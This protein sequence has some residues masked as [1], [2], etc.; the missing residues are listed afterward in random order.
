LNFDARA[1]GESIWL[2]AEIGKKRIFEITGLA[3]HSMYPLAK[4]LW[5]RRHEPDTFANT[6]CFLALPSYLLTRMGLPP[7]VDYSL[8]SRYLP[9]DI[10][11]LKW[12]NDLLTAC[13]LSA[14]F[15]PTPVPAGAIAGK[16]PLTVASELGLRDRPMVVVGGHDQ[17][18][19]ALGCGVL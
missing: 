11:K 12:S 10:G 16:L 2:A 3:V 8:A 15:L 5:L 6:T 18:C 13:E 19:G 7:Y 9:F 14:E 4:V 1:Q 17:P